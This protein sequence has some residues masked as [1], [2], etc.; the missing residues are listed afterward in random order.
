MNVFPSSALLFLKLRYLSANRAP[1]PQPSLS[2]PRARRFISVTSG[3]N[4]DRV[5]SN[6]DANRKHNDEISSCVSLL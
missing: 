2:R 3:H 6:T 1:F 4:D 5:Q